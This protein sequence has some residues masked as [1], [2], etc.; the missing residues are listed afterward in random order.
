MYPILI[1]PIKIKE[2]RDIVQLDDAIRIGSSV[3]L[4]EMEEALRCEIKNKPGSCRFVQ[5]F[6]DLQR[7]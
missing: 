6:S 5:F 2:L 7:Y 3:T 1:Q 4:V